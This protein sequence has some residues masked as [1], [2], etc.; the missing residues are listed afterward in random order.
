MS[1]IAGRQ[2]VKKNSGD[3][4]SRQ[5]RPAKA[6]PRTHQLRSATT[7]TAAPKKFLIQLRVVDNEYGVSEE[8]FSRMMDELSLNQTELVHKALRNLAREILPAYE[9]DNGPLDDKQHA[10]IRAMSGFGDLDP[11]DFESPLL[12]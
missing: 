11:D 1:K 4:K 2:A 5:D 8:T 7:A 10:A 3:G 9:M 12:K 6:Q